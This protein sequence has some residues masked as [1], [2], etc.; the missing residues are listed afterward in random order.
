MRV[1]GVRVAPAVLGCLLT[2]YRTFPDPCASG[3][4]D[5]TA[6]DAGVSSDLCAVARIHNGGYYLAAGAGGRLLTSPDGLAWT[7]HSVRDPVG[8]TVTATL[9]AIAEGASRVV[10]VGEGT[11]ITGA[12]DSPASISGWQAVSGRDRWY[13]GVAC[14]PAGQ[15][16]VAVGGL[17]TEE[18][19]FIR[20]DMAVS[21]DG[22]AWSSVDVGGIG[23]LHAVTHA[24]GLFVAT[25]WGGQILTSPN[26]SDWTVRQ[27]VVDFSMNSAVYGSEGFLVAGLT[28]LLYTSADGTV[29][30]DGW[31]GGS[32]DLYGAAFGDGV[33]CT[34]GS[35]AAI[36]TSTDTIHWTLHDAGIP[37]DDSARLNAVTFHNHRFLV[38]GNGGI[39]LRSGIFADG[40]VL[41]ITVEPPDA[42]T[43]D[44]AAGEAHLCVP[45]SEVTVTATAAAGYRF[46]HWA[47]DLDGTLPSVTVPM[48]DHAALTACFVLHGV[49]SEE[50]EDAAVK[51]MGHTVAV[52]PGGRPALFG[53]HGWDFV[54]LD[55]AEIWDPDAKEFAVR[56]MPM[57]FDG[58]AFV[59]MGDGRYLLAGGAQAD[60]GIPPGLRS[61]MVF[62]PADDTFNLVSGQMGHGRMH[63]RG[64]AL[65]DGRVL[66]VGGWYTAASAA[67]GDIYTPST[68]AF[69][70]TGGLCTPR[71]WT[72]VLPTADG[73][74]VVAGGT[75]PAGSPYI[76]QTEYYDPTTNT[77]SVHG[78][79]L[80]PDEPGWILNTDQT[81]DLGTQRN[82]AGEYVLHVRRADHSESALAL[83]DP[84]VKVFRRLDLTPR[85]TEFATWTFA[86][87]VSPDRN[88]AFVIMS[89]H[90][91]GSASSSS[92]PVVVDLSTGRRS[93]APVSSVTVDYWVGGSAQI[94]LPDGR[95]HVSGGSEA[96][97]HHYNF[98]PVEHTFHLAADYILG[99][100]SVI[101]HDLYEIRTS[102]TNTQM[103][104]DSEGRLHVTYTRRQW[105]RP[106]AG[107]WNYV[108]RSEDDGFTWGNRVRTESMPDSSR[109]F[110]LALGSDDTLHQGFTFN[111]GAY[112]TSSQDGG[113]TWSSP[114]QM[115]DGGWGRYDYEPALAVDPADGALHVAFAQYFGWDD[116]PANVIVK[117][118][119][120]SGAG[121]RSGVD[122]TG[123]PNDDACGTGAANCRMCPA[124][125][126]R[127]F[128]V[129]DESTPTAGRRMISL[130]DGAA[131]HGPVAVSAAG[132]RGWGGDGAVDSG[133]WLHLV[134]LER[135]GGAGNADLHYAVYSPLGRPASAVRTLTDRDAVNVDA[136]TIG[137]YAGDR[138]VIA[139]GL[140]DAGTGGGA[141][142][143]GVY[144]LNSGSDFRRSIRVS[145][146]ARA[147]T[148]GLRSSFGMRQPGKIDIIWVEP[149]PEKEGGGEYLMHRLLVPDD[150]NLDRGILSVNSSI[151]RCSFVL[152]G[153]RTYSGGTGAEGNWT[154]NGVPVG[155]YTIAWEARAG[156]T[157]PAETSLCLGR[158]ETVQFT[159][160]YVPDSVAVLTVST[161][162]AAGDGG[163]VR[164]DPAGELLAPG[165]IG[166][167]PGTVVTL[168]AEPAAGWRF[169]GWSGAAAGD[170]LT[171]TVTVDS[172]Q[173]V[174]AHFTLRESFRI[175]TAAGPHGTIS[176]GFD[177]SYG[178]DAIVTITPDPGAE[179]TTVTVND[180]PVEA[181]TT[182]DLHDVRGD[183]TVQAMFS[184]PRA[185]VHCLREPRHG[186]TVESDRDSYL[187]GETA[188]LTAVPAPGFRFSR[189]S[190]DAAGTEPTTAL[191]VSGDHAVKAHFAGIRVS[192]DL[193]ADGLV[194]IR[195][196]EEAYRMAIGLAA[197]DLARADL[198]HST[199]VTPRDAGLILRTAAGNLEKTVLAL[200]L[201]VTDQ[202]QTASVP[203]R[204]TVTIPGGLLHEP[205]ELTVTE[206]GGPPPFPRGLLPGSPMYRFALGGLN[207]F[208]RDVTLEFD[209]DPDALAPSDA[210]VETRLLA[211]HW[212]DEQLCW[213]FIPS[214][215]DTARRRLVVPTRHFSIIGILNPWQQVTA[216]DPVL[217]YYDPAVSPGIPDMSFC[218]IHQLSA[219][220]GSVFRDVWDCYREKGYPVRPYR[221]DDRFE[222]CVVFLQD[223]WDAPA[224]EPAYSW[225]T[226]TYEMPVS[227]PDRTQLDAAIAHE[228]FHM[229]Q[230]QTFSVLGNMGYNRALM[231]MSAEYAARRIP[232]TVPFQT[233]LLERGEG[234]TTVNGNHEY[235]NACFLDY[236]SRCGVDFSVLWARL[237][238][239]RLVFSAFEDHVFE[240]TGQPFD[241]VYR[242]FRHAALF[243][244]DCEAE[245]SPAPPLLVYWEKG[246]EHTVQLEAGGERA[247]DYAKVVLRSSDPAPAALVAVESAAP[248]PDGVVLQA[249]RLPGDRRVPGGVRPEALLSGTPLHPYALIPCAR[250]D[251]VYVTA[252]SRRA[253]TAAR[254]RILRPGLTMEPS[255]IE[256]ARYAKWYTFRVTANPLPDGTRFVR[257]TW[258]F[259][260]GS[261]PTVVEREPRPATNSFS[262]MHAFT[263]AETATHTVTFT[264]ED[265]D[266]SWIL[267]TATSAVCIESEPSVRFDSPV[268]VLVEGTPVEFTTS[269]EF[270]PA[271]PLYTWSFGDGTPGTGPLAGSTAV[272]TYATSGD[273]I[274]TVT[275]SGAGDPG[276][277]LAAGS[278]RVIVDPPPRDV[279]PDHTCVPLSGIDYAGLRRVR[280]AYTGGTTNVYFTTAAGVRH[281]RFHRFREDGTTEACVVFVNGLREGICREYWGP[282]KLRR[283]V[284]YIGDVRDGFDRG[285]DEEGGV[286]WEQ[287]YVAGQMEGEAR[288]WLGW[289]EV[290]PWPELHVPAGTYDVLW[291]DGT[292]RER[293]GFAGNRRHGDCIRYHRSGAVEQQG[294]FAHG[295]KTGAWL[296]VDA[297]GI[298]ATVN[299]GDETGGVR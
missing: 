264:L 227:Y 257:Y 24:N 164:P 100:P 141:A 210:P 18:P 12:S 97:D 117:T 138:V 244:A 261:E 235:A 92:L 173:A 51:R 41:Q 122:L 285:W 153:P 43:T 134:W 291:P 265:A 128:A 68:G 63:C 80:F 58:G 123:Y 73:G 14:D 96:V 129:F 296:Y 127:R 32:L 200:P 194:D 98:R 255:R 168:Q 6:A 44:P 57:A 54:R 236:L 273:Y 121:W 55:T 176:P 213:R 140:A 78:A 33:Y 76:E 52:L 223:R 111:V 62:D 85:L 146:N 283:E 137:I 280:E 175:T 119:P 231:E 34:V 178:G 114:V 53:G 226:G 37:N 160:V 190:G 5:W 284:H 9:S 91:P 215:A 249:F 28:G 50:G 23:P 8:A 16:Y 214:V 13:R 272:H 112:V 21:H 201:E 259:G 229:V 199:T 132:R 166:Y 251:G 256:P 42:G 61:A 237:T 101:D 136:A 88:Q 294:T 218:D 22:T 207:E 187:P 222:P 292:L 263:A 243:D 149:A 295:V 113:G 180:T 47:G 70:P 298:P 79:S 258:D 233:Y 267:G 94:L 102:P 289:W 209:Y 118:R 198:D 69:A 212:D 108:R 185:I 204:V 87:L 103:V 211:G 105:P 220:A 90:P 89:S 66:V 109:A 282:G 104:R 297:A 19:W 26:G 208:D 11:I 171:T 81:R 250:G 274:A 189:W 30:S 107:Y 3:L 154:E 20:T 7:P 248:V 253:G 162:P 262:H 186:G 216:V 247:L 238:E 268:V 147:R 270:L 60:L 45:G 170:G 1:L 299:H 193:N 197:P 246:L 254:V 148:P 269:G 126:G 163:L 151:P 49:E 203:G 191:V 158:D 202:D 56:S 205:A 232:W 245:Y 293:C 59:R 230:N 165:M 181:A 75:G 64:A 133:G 290:T 156:Y 115:S 196:A 241:T 124:P 278:C 206:I 179:I 39:V 40:P 99:P 161:V 252:Y 31:R 17:H 36:E 10:V 72:L 135:D 27:G 234:L 155:T 120:A 217:V 15:T 172:G 239:S 167:P 174:C 271:Q 71:A 260:D 286:A 242:Q 169:S 225:K 152:T 288:I 188:V 106:L 277:A 86:P 139:Y 144:V 29:W 74:A 195:D 77:F 275:V 145:D 46:S 67:S 276:T 142:Y 95:V 131:W 4:D 279:Y 110:S 25:G 2:L 116:P 150:L 157:T 184:L 287:Y 228:L 159:G 48:D 177:V 240:K 143:R 281:G 38:V 83:F 65:T 182:V 82:A 35:Y 93:T 224:M 219:Y 266:T 130:F 125:G 221:M 84:G 192:G 183:V